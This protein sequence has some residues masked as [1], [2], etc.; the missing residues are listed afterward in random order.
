MNLQMD[1]LVL[2]KLVVQTVMH[3][4]MMQRAKN[5]N[6]IL[7]FNITEEDL[8]KSVGI[9]TIMISVNITTMILQY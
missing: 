2:L 5:V 3:V 8:Y 7:N 6:Q 4:V 1:S 9:R